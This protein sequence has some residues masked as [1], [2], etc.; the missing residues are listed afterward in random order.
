[1]RLGQLA[2]KLDTKPAAIIEFVKANYGIALENDLNTRIE[3][4][5]AQAFAESVNGTLYTMTEETEANESVLDQETN[6]S[7]IEK[8]TTVA[9]PSV[10]PIHVPIEVPHYH[11]ATDEKNEAILDP[12]IPLPVDP[13]AELIKAP[14]IK[15]EGLK[16]LGKIELPETKK[17]IQPEADSTEVAAKKRGNK[18][19]DTIESEDEFENSIYKDKNG[20]YHFSQTQK[21][22]R[23]NSLARIKNEKQEQL[24]KQ[25]QVKHYQQATQSDKKTISKK[26]ETNKKQ[27]PTPQAKPVRKGLWGKFLNWLN[28]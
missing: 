5:H 12:F 23:K 16:V 22:N 6:S 8:E 21:E 17:E 1:M 7:T 28:D 18:S 4:E 20:I 19:A 3:D 26:K 10:E 24:R 25:K 9:E 15:L 13:D 14:K 11:T 2:R 27:K